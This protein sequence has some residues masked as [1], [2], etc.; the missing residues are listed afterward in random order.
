MRGIKFELSNGIDTFYFFHSYLGIFGIK[1]SPYLKSDFSLINLKVIVIPLNQGIIFFISEIVNRRTGILLY[2]FEK[3]TRK[4]E[5][6]L[7]E[8]IGNFAYYFILEMRV[9][10]IILKTFVRSVDI[11]TD[12]LKIYQIRRGTNEEYQRCMNL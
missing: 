7:S 10:D 8:N 1:I 6:R 4:C 11:S 5:L 9:S 2:K 3:F 12:N